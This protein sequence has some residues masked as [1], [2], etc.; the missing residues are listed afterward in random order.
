MKRFL[1]ISSDGHAGPQ[2]QGYREYVDSKYHD[3]FDVALAQQIAQTKEMEKMFPH[4]PMAADYWV[5]TPN[6]FFN[7]RTPLELMVSEGLEGLRLV[8]EHLRGSGDWG[9][10]PPP[11]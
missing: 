1:A 7:Q 10:V 4:N 3:Q 5:T 2:P 9:S 6:R 8:I 11:K